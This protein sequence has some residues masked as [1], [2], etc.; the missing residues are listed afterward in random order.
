MLD[1]DGDWRSVGSGGGCWVDVFNP[2]LDLLEKYVVLS[3]GITGS[4]DGDEAVSFSG[5]LCSSAV[6]AVET[7]DAL[8]RRT[9]PVDPARPFFVVGVLGEGR[10]RILDEHQGVLRGPRGEALDFPLND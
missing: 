8:G 5:G 7:I 3:T 4:G 6:A 9:F 1:E 10:V 2:P